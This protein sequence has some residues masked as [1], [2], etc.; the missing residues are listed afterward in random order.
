[1]GGL[2][3]YNEGLIRN[4]YARGRILGSNTSVVGGLIAASMDV[5]GLPP[6]VAE[7][8]YWDSDMSGQMSSAGG[9]SKTTVELQMPTTAEGIYEDWSV[10]DWDFGTDQQYPI[11]K[12]TSAT[13]ILAEPA[14]DADPETILPPC[15]TTVPNQSI[16]L[17]SLTLS[18]ESLST[19]LMPPFN[20]AIT[21]YRIVGIANAI[22]HTTITAS[23]LQGINRI[24]IKSSSLEDDIE[25]NALELTSDAIPLTEGGTTTITIVVTAQTGGTNQ[26]YTVAIERLA[27][28]DAGL[29]EL[30]IVGESGSIKLI[31]EFST[32]RTEYMG[33]VPGDVAVSINTAATHSKA[34]I[35]IAKAG[36]QPTPP[37]R[38]QARRRIELNQ[39]T[40]TTI[41]ITVTAQDGVNTATYTVKLKRLQSS[42]ATLRSLEVVG[43]SGRKFELT[44]ISAIKYSAEVEG[45]R[46]ISIHATAHPRATIEVIKDKSL[47]AS[48]QTRQGGIESELIELNQNTT[49]T[50]IVRVTPEDGGT[51]QETTIE[52]RYLNTIRIQIR[53]FLE[54]LLQ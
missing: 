29:A 44:R 41:M 4:S 51:P 17:Q 36:S 38:G 22:D 6:A 47:V 53:V 50:I 32:T 48:Q 46:N 35:Q 33:T 54:G 28:S 8:S 30:Q 39:A 18:V 15:D 26:A 40:T 20:P 10:A 19:P 52:I 13:D 43:S 49:T 37:M 31:P 25:T 5:S 14:C 34:T 11:V 42:D 2:T 1:M 12:S 45:D 27:S 7:A 21:S 23:A 16:V 3:A 9:T 24:S